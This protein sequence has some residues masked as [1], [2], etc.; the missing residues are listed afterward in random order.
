[1]ARDRPIIEVRYSPRVPAETMLAH[2]LTNLA[3]RHAELRPHTPR[4]EPLVLVAGG[5][6]LLETLEDVAAASVAGAKVLAVNEVPQLLMEYGIRP[7]A[8]VHVGPDALTLSAMGTP[9]EGLRYYLASICPPEA[10]ERLAHH[11]AVLWHPQ[12]DGL[13]AKMRAAGADPAAGFIGGG[14]TVAL[15]C[16]ELA[17][18]LGFRRILFHG[19][20]SSFKERFHAYASV[21]DEIEIARY[22]V[23]CAGREFTSTAELVGQALTFPALKEKLA[24]RSI[25]IEIMGDGLLP[26]L[27]RS[28]A[29]TGT[30][31]P[32]RLIGGNA[33]IET[34]RGCAIIDAE[35]F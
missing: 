3:G 28:A 17:A 4:R 34:R 15:R 31:P 9:I 10:F 24:R 23:E 35:M 20:D 19:V 2:L 33:E 29:E 6:S 13:E 18:T 21:A 16:L 25:T 12:V 7:W 26:H 22:R 5:P 11:N 8:A 30:I 1:M 14:N 27:A 32:A